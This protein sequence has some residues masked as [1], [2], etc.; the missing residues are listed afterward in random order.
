MLMTYF[1]GFFLF[2]CISAWR[3]IETTRFNV[4]AATIWPIT[5]WVVLITMLLDLI[6]WE[7][8]IDKGDKPFNW[9]KPYDNWP[10]F[11]V[12]IFRYEIKFW[13]MR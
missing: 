12:T 11:A 8:T 6:R 10:G 1:V 3:N 4:L 5:I 2:I 13:K 9:R 7:W